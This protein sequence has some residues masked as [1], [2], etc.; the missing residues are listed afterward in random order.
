MRT[1]GSHSG[2]FGRR[3]RPSTTWSRFQINAV[4]DS[5]RSVPLTR[6]RPQ[7]HGRKRGLDHVHGPQMPPLLLRE[8]RERDEALPILVHAHGLGSHRL[9]S[10]RVSAD[11][12]ALSKVVVSGWCVLG[13]VS[14][15]LRIRWFQQRCSAVPFPY[16]SIV[17]LLKRPY[18]SS[19]VTGRYAA[20][21]KVL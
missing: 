9:P 8:P 13:I 21:R 10:T 11:G 15:T 17:S 7:P 2:A 12:M 4:A 16:L 20:V 18:L 5:T 14:S 19:K 6:R 1:R 3:K